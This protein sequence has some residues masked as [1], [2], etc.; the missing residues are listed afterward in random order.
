MKKMWAKLSFPTPQDG[1]RVACRLVDATSDTRGTA[2]RTCTAASRLRYLHALVR[3][4]A[5]RRTA[6]AV[7]LRSRVGRRQPG[8][9]SVRP[10]ERSR[11]FRR[12]F[13]RPEG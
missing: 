10:A 12:E 6:L 11:T 9:C 3:V 13:G 8:M 5:D 2:P 1:P 4:V 7:R